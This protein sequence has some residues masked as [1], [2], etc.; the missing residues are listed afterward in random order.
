MPDSPKDSKRRSE[1]G[2]PYNA[3]NRRP[4][5]V[6][7]VIVYMPRYRHGHEADFVPPITGIYLAALTPADYQVRVIH[8][9]VQPVDLDTGADL[10]A[11]SFFTGFAPEAYRLA[12]EF[13]KRGKLV[14][15]GGPHVTFNADE[16]L[17]HVD[18]VVLGEAESIWT[19]LLDDA[20]TGRLRSR[21][22]GIPQPLAGLPTPRYDLL[23]GN[24]W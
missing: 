14:V 6:E 3:A 7:I 20:V 4:F 23:R 2:T 15:A 22:V 19:Q 1:P 13:R 11:L 17:E 8:Q 24:F 9:Q 5:C 21:Y 10:I 16:A 18:S 12:D